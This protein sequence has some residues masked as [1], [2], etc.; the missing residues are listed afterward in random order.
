MDYKKALQESRSKLTIKSA[1]SH[2]S[3]IGYCE[4]SIC[5]RLGLD[6]I[7]DI[8]WRAIPIYRKERLI[9]RDALDLAIDIFL[10]QGVV[11]T[12]EFD[13]LFDSHMQEA[14]VQCGIISIEADRCRANISCYPVGDSFIFSDHAWPKLPHPGCLS[15]PHEQVMYIGTDSRWLVHAT[16]RRDFDSA[17]DLCTGSGIHAVFAAK[18]ANRVVAIDINPRAVQCTAFNA[19]VIDTANVEAL[20]GDLYEP[21]GEERF[22]LI[23]ANPPFV[24]SPVDALGYRDGGRDGESVQRRI[25]EGLPYHLAMGGIAQIV[26]EFGER[27]DESLLDRLRGWL[28]GA[29][30]DILIL[31]LRSHS[32]ANYAISHADGDD[33]YEAF[34]NSV[35][36]WATNLRAQGYTQISSVLVAFKWSD[37]ASGEPW[38]RIDDVAPPTCDIGFAIEEI[39]AVEGLCRTPDLFESLKYKKIYRVGKIGILEASELG[40]RASRA[41]ANLLGAPL[42]ISKW[43]DPDELNILLALQKPLTLSELATG[44]AVK[45]EMLFDKV[46]LLIRSGLLN[47]A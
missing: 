10:L 12:K 43:L 23:T 45:E 30:M 16:V 31:R 14:L 35:D 13:L 20:L 26:T 47:V 38:G 33:T 3:D 40:G 11:S 36:D 17:L 9:A 2:L 5:E 8:T 46:C 34:L 37:S 24:P 4:S 25:I 15:V 6:E 32:A 7:T 44:F 1:L 28:K 41:Q 27:E 42:T 19:S 21:I 22:E 39:F 18:H 29:P